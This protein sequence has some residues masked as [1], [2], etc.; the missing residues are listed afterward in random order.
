[1]TFNPVSLLCIN[2]N[3]GTSITRPV[4]EVTCYKCGEKVRLSMISV[5]ETEDSWLERTTCQRKSNANQKD[6]YFRTFKKEGMR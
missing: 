3:E 6:G 5:V 2:C 4:D 1:M